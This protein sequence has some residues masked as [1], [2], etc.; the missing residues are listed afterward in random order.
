MPTRPSGT[1]H[2]G[3]GHS[4]TLSW[5]NRRVAEAFGHDAEAYDRARPRYPDALVTR[6]IVESPGQEV[7]DVG[8]GTGIAARLFTTA[9]CRVLGVD[10]DARM[11]EVARRGGIE[12]EI[13]K[14]E[15][16]DPAGRT[17]DIVVSG[18]A[19]HWVDPVAGAVK[20]AQVL[21][22][23]GR[24]AVFWNAD[25]PPTDLAAAFGEV[26]RR[27][28]PDALV[29][30]RWV[31]P[32]TAL[33]GCRTLCANA[34][35]GMQAADAYDDPDQ[36]RFDWQ[37][38]YTRAEWLDQVPTTGD[39]NQFPRAQLDELL[40]GLGAAID[41]VGGSF[42]MRYTTVVCTA[43]RTVNRRPGGGAVGSRRAPQQ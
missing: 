12:V 11:A 4:S 27:V 26:Y 6:I 2:S 13:G 33:E 7:L 3:T 9:G 28:M 42:P 24:L 32:Q 15:C 35:E 23:H 22:P 36:W 1:G 40:A 25:E 5:E 43:T 17:F 29:T 14:F 30:R 38:T 8:V 21:R 31:A 20:A 39:H 34:S 37:R 18:Q 19:W 41:A 10:V 16:W